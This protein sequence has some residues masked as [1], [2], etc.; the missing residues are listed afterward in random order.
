M[1]EYTGEIDGAPLTLPRQWP[2]LKTPGALEQIGAG[3]QLEN[4]IVGGLSQGMIPPPEEQPFKSEWDVRDV[5]TFDEFMTG[6]FDGAR[7]D[8]QVEAIR[9][10]IR[11]EEQLRDTFARGPLAPIAVGLFAA[12]VDP[13][14]YLGPFTA[15]FKAAGVGGRVLAGAADAALSVG[16]SEA[17]LSGQNLR[18]G[19]EALASMLMG[20]A[21]GAGVGAAFGPRTTSPIGTPLAP[22]AK[23]TSVRD[24]IAAYMEAVARDEGS[25][26]RLTDTTA[27]GRF[28]DSPSLKW[29]FERQPPPPGMLDDG[30]LLRFAMGRNTRL[31]DNVEA[32][33]RKLEELDNPLSLAI[34]RTAPD[35]T[36]SRIERDGI[37][38]QIIDLEGRTNPAAQAARAEGKSLDDILAA[39]DAA[40]SARKDPVAMAQAAKLR[41]RL[42]ELD[43]TL[44]LRVD[45]GGGPLTWQVNKAREAAAKE[46]QDALAK[47]HAQ[48]ERERAKMAKLTQN[49]GKEGTLEAH[50]RIMELKDAL[51]RGAE[52]DTPKG[53]W[54][55]EI[56]AFNK[57]KEKPKPAGFDDKAKAAA[58]QRKLDER[59]GEVSPTAA[60]KGE[61]IDFI[62]L[63]GGL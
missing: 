43:D 29:T 11:R 44:P 27:V 52:V 62:G 22:T 16:V 60:A 20:T 18:S 39:M 48:L 38:S 2:D 45:D 23:Y 33:A 40:P 7:D 50:A 4:S 35:L 36:P 14:T 51:A 61:N 3:L 47:L 32:A 30:N 55:D 49:L 13:F 54:L 8:R 26:A 42:A 10:N 25:L 56:A 37:I 6:R 58:A 5:V 19:S 34:A 63:C 28:L 24:E 15:P 41:G 9:S 57:A 31:F 21:F 59:G 53:N 1:A 17:I 46:Y 12:G